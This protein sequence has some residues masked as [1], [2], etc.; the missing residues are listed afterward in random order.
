MWL[1]TSAPTPGPILEEYELVSV[2]L[3]GC[4]EQYQKIHKRI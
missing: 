4:E 2:Y 1:G 3:N